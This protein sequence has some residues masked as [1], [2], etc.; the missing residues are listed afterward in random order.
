MADKTTTSYE[1]K[2]EFLFQ[3]GDTRVLTLKNPKSTITSAEIT[4]IENLIKDTP[5][6]QEEVS[7]PLLVGDRANGEFRRINL[8]TRDTIT[9][10]T[11]DLGS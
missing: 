9:K 10:T 6:S 5:T 1:L 3:D 4:A 2:F 7:T 8:V 11:M